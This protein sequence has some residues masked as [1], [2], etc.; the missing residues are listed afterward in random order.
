MSK[1]LLICASLL[2]AKH[3]DKKATQNNTQ[4]S[5]PPVVETYTAPF[6]GIWGESTIHIDERTYTCEYNTEN[7]LYYFMG[8]D[9][10]TIVEESCIAAV[11]VWSHTF[12]KQLFKI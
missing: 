12:Q 8:S 1:I 9:G 11:N 4:P 6:I 2:L 5:L 7:K 3:H 10:M